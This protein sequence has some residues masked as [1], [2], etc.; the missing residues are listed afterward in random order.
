VGHLPYPLAGAKAKVIGSKIYLFGGFGGNGY[1]GFE[2][3]ILVADVSSPTN[4]KELGTHLFAK[5]MGGSFVVAGNNAYLLGGQN[6][7]GVQST[8]VSSPVSYAVSGL[9]LANYGLNS[10]EVYLGCS[11]AA[12]TCQGNDIMYTDSSGNTSLVTTCV[13]PYACVNG[14]STCLLPPPDCT[15]F[16]GTFNGNSFS[17]T[18]C[19]QAMPKLLTRSNQ[20][21]LYWNDGTAGASAICNVTGSNGDSW[22]GTF[23][24]AAG[25]SSTINNRTT[26]TLSCRSAPGAPV[27]TAT[28][29]VTPNPLY[30]EL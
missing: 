16:T 17:A 3:R 10:W 9:Q 20:T 25:V 11:T 29:V 6:S 19:L 23:S 14:Q 5:E 30:H 1:Y 8:I 13:A 28:V 22:T 26:F 24:G 12:Y 7:G 2:P 18:G 15:P 27:Q 21:Q 4:F